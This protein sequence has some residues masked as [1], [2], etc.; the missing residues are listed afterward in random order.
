MVSFVHSCSFPRLSPY[1]VSAF[2]YS[3]LEGWADFEVLGFL[4]VSFRMWGGGR[5]E[6]CFSTSEVVMRSL[7]PVYDQTQRK[8][9]NM[10]HVLAF[11]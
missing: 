6:G 2:R 11:A 1:P 4:F 8:L 10:I 9:P 5:G 7:R 3:W